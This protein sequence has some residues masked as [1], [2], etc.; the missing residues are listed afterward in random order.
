MTVCA[1]LVWRICACQH[2]AFGSESCMW[3]CQACE[4]VKHVSRNT[5]ACCV[6]DKLFAENSTCSYCGN[7]IMK[8]EDADVDHIIPFT[9]GGKTEDTN[10]Q[11]LHKACNQ[12]KSN[13]TLDLS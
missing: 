9:K 13:H 1:C 11:L 6:Q 2:F 8:L 7:V 3:G 5:L 10:A 12:Q 4:G